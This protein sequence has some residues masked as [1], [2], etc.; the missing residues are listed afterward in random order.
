MSHPISLLLA[1]YFKHTRET[2]FEMNPLD[3]QIA[4]FPFAQVPASLAWDSI[5]IAQ[6][7]KWSHRMLTS[8]D[9]LDVD[10]HCQGLFKALGFQAAFYVVQAETGLAFL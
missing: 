2:Q 6:S 9:G 7:G 8:Q 1:G 10:G 4:V 5:P 3:M